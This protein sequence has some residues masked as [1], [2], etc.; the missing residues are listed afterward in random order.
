M[1][2]NGVKI[3]VNNVYKVERAVSGQELL[4]AVMAGGQ[5]LEAYAKI[6][7]NQVFSGKA[8]NHLAGSIQTVKDSVT[9]TG[10]FVNVGPTVVYGR[11][12]ELGGIIKPVFKKFLHFFIDD[13][14]IFT[15]IVR[16]P[17]RPYLRPAFDEHQ[18]D[19]EDAVGF[20]VKKL[21]E[22]ATK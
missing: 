6:N 15:K 21:I 13:K 18:K 10:A 4:K 20:Q 11:I 19:I 14:E 2:D 7:A 5:V 9:A 8:L 12:H 22:G 1:K 16:M 17:A 3:L